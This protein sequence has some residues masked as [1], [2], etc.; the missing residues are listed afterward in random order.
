M[1]VSLGRGL[2]HPE[3]AVTMAR[4]GNAIYVTVCGT[5]MFLIVPLALWGNLTGPTENMFVGV[6]AT[7]IVALAI[8]AVAWV[9]RYV[10]P[11]K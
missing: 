6:I 10:W 7:V 2:D 9:I 4:L 3:G 1:L 5:L 8:W 11:A